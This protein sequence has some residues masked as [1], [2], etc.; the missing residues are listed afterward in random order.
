MATPAFVHGKDGTISIG[1]NQFAALSFDCE[2]SCD[3]EDITFA[4][5][6]ATAQVM[7]PG[8]EKVSGSISFVYDTANKPTV[9]P[10]NMKPGTLMTLTL[11]PDGVDTFSFSAYSGS[12]KFTSGP[13]GGAVKCTTT[14]ASTGPITVPTS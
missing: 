10:Q 2:H 7:I 5:G 8:Y 6:G 12:F 11:K 4:A 9:S 14:F 1:G 3:L 13:Q